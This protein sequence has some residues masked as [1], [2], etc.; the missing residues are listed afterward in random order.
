MAESIQPT[1][2]TPAFHIRPLDFNGMEDIQFLIDSYDASLVQLASIGS[3]G[4]WG[5]QKFAERPDQAEK[6]KM[7]EEIK[8]YYLT[9][10][11][12]PIRYFIAE[13]EIPPSAV[14][15]LPVSVRIRTD[16]DGKKFLAVGSVM[17]T[18]GDCPYYIR[19]Q[20]DKDSVKTALEGR[21]D[22]IY[23][24]GL[25]TDFRTGSWRKG[26]GAVLIE[27]ARQYCREKG[28]RSIF[29]DSYAG[30]GRKLVK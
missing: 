5:T 29:L 2:A 23:L 1:S 20:F 4:Q 13:V 8:E 17:I 22:Y 3:G 21:D 27:Y 14:D 6:T 9:G 30:N 15:E 24:E 7:F 10:K 26:S 16:G 19:L 28:K 11:G 25:I 12:K 18:E